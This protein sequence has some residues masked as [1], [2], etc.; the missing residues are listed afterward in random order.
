MSERVSERVGPCR[1]ED[2]SNTYLEV[3]SLA[4]RAIR[5]IHVVFVPSVALA[6]PPPC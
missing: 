5:V 1:A 4:V 2:C 6:Q 3:P